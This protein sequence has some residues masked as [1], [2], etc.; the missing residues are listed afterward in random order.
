[1]LLSILYHSQKNNEKNWENRSNG[2]PFR[3]W[4]SSYNSQFF[5]SVHFISEAKLDN[6]EFVLLD[7][8]RPKHLQSLCDATTPTSVLV[9]NQEERFQWKPDHDF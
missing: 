5:H 6:Q 1:M 9:L 7:A 3:L 4:H 2:F 8:F